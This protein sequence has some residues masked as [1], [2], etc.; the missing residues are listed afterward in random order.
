MKISNLLLG[1]FFFVLV[2]FSITT[3]I[4]YK[5]SK[6]IIDNVK[7]VERSTAIVRNSNRFQGNF[8]NMISGLRGYLLTEE[9]SFLQTYD[10]AIRENTKILVELN[11]LV[12]ENSEQKIVLD[13]IRELQKYWVDE[14]AAP[15]L[16]AKTQISSEQ[17]KARFNKLYREKLGNRLDKDIQVSLQKKFSEFV[18]Q[19]YL[20]RAS[21]QENLTLSVKHTKSVSFYLT[22]ISIVLGGCIAIFIARYISVRLV[23]MVTMAN[24]IASGNYD[25]HVQNSG[26][27]EISQLATALNNMAGILGTN[28]SLLKRQRDELDQFAHIV[29]HDLKAP[30][31]GIDNIVKWIEEDHSLQLPPEVLEYIELIKG[32]IARAENLLKGILQYARVSRQTPPREIVDLNEL[33]AEM[34]IDI[35]TQEAIVFEVQPDLPLLYTQRTP[36]QQVFSNLIVN[37]FKYHDKE[38]GFVKVYYRVD[39][40][41]CHFFVEDNGPGIPKMYHNKIFR[42][43]QTLHERDT[44]ESVGVGLAI[45]RKIL[46]DR[47]LH[48][49]ITTPESGIGTIFSF[50]WPLNEIH[51]TNYSYSVDRR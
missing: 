15:L 30:L 32:R 20:F 9:T 4:N 44:I 2:L 26:G 31:R 49:S 35:G 29:S 6:L 19:E 50:T 41:Y 17:D 51:E 3:Y 43:F 21:G 37:A 47:N 25:V 28:F 8:L 38:N 39:G 11:G 45:V 18:N 23:R 33:I 24:E 7:N 14:F 22:I 5:Q 27:S 12:P 13:D 40:D 1:S 48:I 42:I 36:L 46:E 10:S 34:S 16:E